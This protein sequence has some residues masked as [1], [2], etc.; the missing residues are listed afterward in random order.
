M[1][2]CFSFKS[3]L[4]VSFIVPETRDASIGGFTRSSSNN[5]SLNIQDTGKL[6][7]NFFCSKFRFC[8]KN[9]NNIILCCLK[10]LNVYI[11]IVLSTQI[12]GDLL[13]GEKNSRL[14]SMDHN[15]IPEEE[16]KTLQVGTSVPY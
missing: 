7:N 14:P 6:Y 2:W 16:P 15:Y 1:N 10:I 12:L 5:T 3:F 8:L 4:F 11:R 13:C 9:Q